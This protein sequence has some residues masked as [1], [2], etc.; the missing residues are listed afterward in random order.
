[1]LAVESIQAEAVVL[2][3]AQYRVDGRLIRELVRAKNALTA[4][5][6]PKENE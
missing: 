1:M 4:L 5:Q 2:D 3:K 6:P